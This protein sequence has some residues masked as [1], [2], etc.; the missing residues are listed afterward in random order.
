[1]GRG[2]L[3]GVTK[4]VSEHPCFCPTGICFSFIPALPGK[5][6][7]GLNPPHI[8]VVRTEHND[9]DQSLKHEDEEKAEGQ[10]LANK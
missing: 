9:P 10:N 4:S 6:Q 8:S 3:D 7:A 2:T 1:M 5:K